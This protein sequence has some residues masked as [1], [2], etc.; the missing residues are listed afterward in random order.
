MALILSID[1]A[2]EEATVCLAEGNMVLAMK[3]NDRQHDHAAWIHQ[4]VAD[5]FRETGRL[6]NLLDA[7]AVT[8]GPGSYTGLRVGMATAKGICYAMNIPL[9]TE[10]ALRLLAERVKREVAIRSVHQFPV[11]ICPM[12]DARRMEVFTCLF[13][14]DLKEHMEAQAVILDE[15][16]LRSEL[17]NHIII[18]C[19]NGSKKWQN[20]CMHKHAVFVDAAHD[21]GDLALAAA[22]KYIQGTFSDLAYAE[23]AY[24]KTFFTGKIK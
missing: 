16:S 2:L 24:L 14:L 1:T 11:L 18:F 3:K 21:A 22:E 8:A 6:V 23:P 4:S 19:G 17:E 15:G 20:L 7:V 12:I 13:D 9:I 5:L 10:S